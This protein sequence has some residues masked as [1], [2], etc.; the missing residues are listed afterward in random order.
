MGSLLGSLLGFRHP[1][2]LVRGF[3]CLG[4]RGTGGLLTRED[5]FLERRRFLLGAETL[6]EFD[7]CVFRFRRVAETVEARLHEAHGRASYPRLAHL[8]VLVRGQQES[9]HV[10][11]PGIK[12]LAVTDV[13]AAATKPWGRGGVVYS[14]RCGA[15]VVR[16]SANT[17]PHLGVR[18]GATVQQAI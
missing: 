12:S 11:V 9:D 5:V 16:D 8:G 15:G 14:I 1:P 18:Y 2:R 4:A 3:F 13:A 17:T 10:G 6:K 7:N